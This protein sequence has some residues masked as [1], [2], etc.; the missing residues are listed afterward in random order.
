MSICNILQ[1][2]LSFSTFYFKFLHAM[3]T[4]ECMLN[5]FFKCYNC[6]ML[7]IKENVANFY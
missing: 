5:G 7:S 1:P 3:H 6:V 2:R 4:M